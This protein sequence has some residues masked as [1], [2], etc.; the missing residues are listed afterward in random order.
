MLSS[1]KNHDHRD[2][3][4]NPYLDQ[5]PFPTWIIDAENF[6]I[7][8]VNKATVAAT[9]YEEYEMFCFCLDQI[10][11]ASSQFPSLM[12]QALGSCVNGK[13]KT[14]SG[15]IV[16]VQIY[17]SEFIY[18]EQRSF[19]LTAVPVQQ[20]QPEQEFFPSSKENSLENFSGWKD[21]SDYSR[22]LANLVEQTTDVLTAS[23]LQYRPLTWNAAAEKVYGLK[24][25]EVIGRDLRDFL[26]IQYTG[27][28][29]E[30]VRDII[31]QL[32]EWRGEA[33]FVRPTDQRPITI[34]IGFKQLKNHQDVPIGY[35]ISAFDISE[36]K[37]A[38]LRLKESEERFREVADSSPV[39]IW[40]C[41]EQHAITYLNRQWID[42]TGVNIQQGAQWEEMVH[43]ED[44]P[45]AKSDY[46]NAFESRAQATLIY[47]LRRFDGSY[48]WVHDVSVPRFLH[49]NQF[50]GY[51]GSVVDI[52]DQKQKQE[53]LLYQATIL[54]NVSDIVVTTDINFMVRVWNKIAEHYYEISA[55]EAIGKRMGELVQFSYP[56]TTME[57]ALYKLQ[58][59][60]I[61]QGET[62]F[63]N[64]KGETV[65]FLHTVKFVQDEKGIRIGYLTVARDITAMKIADQKLKKS[66]QFYRTLIADSLDGILLMN[67]EGMITFASPSVKNVLGFEVEDIIGR[68][69]FDFVHPDDIE[70][71]SDSFQKEVIENPEVKF[72]VVRL[73]RNDG[74][75]I[76][77][78]VRGHNMLKN[79][80]INSIVIYFHDDSLRKQANDALKESEKRF[81]SLIKDLHTG[82]LLQDAEGKTLLWNKA[83][84]EILGVEEETLKAHSIWEIF[85]EGIKEDGTPFSNEERPTLRA[86][87]GKTMVKDVVMGL[88]H[89]S[90]KEYIW[91]ILCIDPILND[92]GGLR[93]LVCSFTDIT[94]RKKLESKILSDEI[95]LQRQL[96]QATIDGQERER[97]EIGKELHDNIGQQLTTIKLFLDIAKSTA[98]DATNEMLNMALKGVSDVINEVRAVSRSLIPSMLN[99]LGLVESVTE[100]VDSITRTE[101]LRI[102][103]HHLHFD[104]D[105]LTENQKLS[106]FRIIQEQLNNIVKHAGAD[107]AWIELSS[108]EKGLLLTIRDDGTGFDLKKTRRGLGF[109]NI[110]NRAELLSG[111]A[112]IISHPGNGCLLKVSLPFP[113]A[114]QN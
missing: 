99:D 2:R 106:L 30:A 92:E 57:R 59:E 71:A 78:M 12:N 23:D 72:I 45:K 11:E 14:K 33:L 36:R 16:P 29:K 38:E 54:E 74:S 42:F 5:F 15:A 48:R 32:G 52:E 24:A 37:E 100:L 68:N 113:L 88:W 26:N 112:E 105:Q 18:Q 109:M 81:R 94:E 108:S 20:F 41:D 9:G 22:L 84:L 69:A 50:I 93:H 82:V 40:M 102:D 10:L 27:Y 7:I 35:L 77:C 19:Q 98:D 83:S 65:Y 107:E 17:S 104:E 1:Q 13:L 28:S 110:K 39:M 73:L 63:L 80:N 53:E 111:N 90:R 25:S 4:S 34:L 87:L 66:E 8:R 56:E 58:H 46:A 31:G 85:P 67:E 62:S 96:T 86:I 89:P 49:D 95:G 97:K 114:E 79:P 44:L 60:G 75:W 64:S 43:P 91:L 55:E 47:R 70:W 3:T 6:S 76:W 61:W 21:A 103:F 51:I 101:L